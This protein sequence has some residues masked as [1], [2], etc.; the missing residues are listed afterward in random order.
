MHEHNGSEHVSS[1]ITLNEWFKK[2]PSCLAFVGECE[3]F[4]DPAIVHT[5]NTKN[6]I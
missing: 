6:L 1:M 3:I 5:Q 2:P 4:H